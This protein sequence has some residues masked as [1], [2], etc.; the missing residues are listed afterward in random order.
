[1]KNIAVCWPSEPETAIGV[2]VHIRAHESQSK[3]NSILQW[4]I[5]D[6]RL[7][8]ELRKWETEHLRPWNTYPIRILRS[9]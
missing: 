5:R 2:T 4:A 7:P 6:V 9:L 3:L 8:N 1:M